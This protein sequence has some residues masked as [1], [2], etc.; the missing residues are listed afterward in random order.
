MFLG[1]DIGR[2]YVKMVAMSKTKEG[3]KLLDAGHRLVPDYELSVPSL[4]F[5]LG[6]S[7]SLSSGLIFCIFFT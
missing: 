7:S 1:L 3:Y 2:Q 4:Y 6:V 5:F